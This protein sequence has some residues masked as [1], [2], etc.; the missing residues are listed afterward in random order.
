MVGCVVVV[1]GAAVVGAAVVGASDGVVLGVVI[2][3]TVVADGV[4]CGFFPVNDLE[5]F[6]KKST[7]R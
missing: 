4:G 3:D 7:V 1:V 5:Y 6:H 2:M